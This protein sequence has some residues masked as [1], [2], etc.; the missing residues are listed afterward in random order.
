MA[1]PCQPLMAAWKAAC[2]A[3]GAVTLVLPP[4]TYYIG[5]VQFHGPCYK[6]TTITFLLQASSCSH[7][8]Y[9]YR[10]RG[11]EQIERM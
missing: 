4:G 6:A 11:H 1:A 3:A 2:A 9:V 8:H 5:P 10:V 7:D